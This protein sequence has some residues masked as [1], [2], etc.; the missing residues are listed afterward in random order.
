MEVL[1]YKEFRITNEMLSSKTKRFL[2]YIIDLTIFYL[3]FFVL[4]ALLYLIAEL[5]I[6]E[7]LIYF[8]DDLDNVNPLLDRLFTAVILVIF[9]TVLEG[10][11]QKTVGKLITQTKVV[12][13]DGEKPPFDVILKRSLSRIIPFEAFSFLGST[14]RGWHDSISKTYVVDV[15]IFDEQKK[16]HENYLL[17]GKEADS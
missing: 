1:N 8:L 7:D 4:G 14:A 11:S 5:T 9:Y 10:F 17:I 16:S 13:E 6:N 12:L 3:M 2:N 15:K